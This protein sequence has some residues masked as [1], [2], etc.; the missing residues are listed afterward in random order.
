MAVNHRK[1]TAMR[2]GRTGAPV[3]LPR[4]SASWSAHDIQRLRRLAEQGLTVETLAQHLR[5]TPS[6]IRNKAAMHGISLRSGRHA[7]R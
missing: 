1:P 4:A 5:R 7:Q 2:G 3:F 6:A